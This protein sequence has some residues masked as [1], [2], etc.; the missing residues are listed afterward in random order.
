MAKWLV[1]HTADGI[2]VQ[3]DVVDAENYEKAYLAALYKMPTHYA[4]G[5]VCSGIISVTLITDQNND[6][7]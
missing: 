2:T 5:T 7:N 1:T 3:T 6:K 4:I